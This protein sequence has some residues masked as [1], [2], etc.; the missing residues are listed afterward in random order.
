M[1]CLSKNFNKNIDKICVFFKDTNLLYEDIFRG[2]DFIFGNIRSNKFFEKT[3]MDLTEI[4]LSKDM[5]FTIKGN[6]G[7]SVKFRINIS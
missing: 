3:I 1:F 7:L 4:I 5:A 6:I 2:N